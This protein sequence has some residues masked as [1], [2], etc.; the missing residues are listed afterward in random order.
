MASLPWDHSE[1]AEHRGH[2][3]YMNLAWHLCDVLSNDGTILTKRVG[4]QKDL[5][6]MMVPVDLS[7]VRCAG[8]RSCLQSSTE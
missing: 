3:L 5:W 8:L 7:H 6:A 4:S 2:S 1:A